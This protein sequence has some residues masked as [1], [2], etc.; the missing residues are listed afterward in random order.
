MNLQRASIDINNINTCRES[1]TSTNR[2]IDLPGD[3]LILELLL[4]NT[5][6]YLIILIFGSKKIG[7]FTVD[8]F[9]SL[10]ISYRLQWEFC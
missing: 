9:K 8:N 7:E 2:E 1:R 6:S 3:K 10:Y 4:Y 5:F